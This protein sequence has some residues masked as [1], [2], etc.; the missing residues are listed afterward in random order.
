MPAMPAAVRRRVRLHRDAAVRRFDVGAIVTQTLVNVGKAIAA[1]ENKLVSLEAPFDRWVHEGKDSTRSR[2]RRSAARTLFVGK[3]SCIDCHN[4]PM[5]TDK[6]FHNIGIPQVGDHVPTAR[7]LRRGQRELRLPYDRQGRD[8]PAVGRV[9]RPVE[10][11]TGRGNKFRRVGSWGDPLSAEPD[12]DVKD[13]ALSAQYCFPVD[14]SL[15]GAWRTPSLRDVAITAPYMHDGYYRTLED[16]VWHY[17]NGGTASGTTTSVTRAGLDDRE[18]A[19]SMIPACA[20]PRSGPADAARRAAQVKPLGLTAEEMSDLV[21][22]LKTLTASR[23]HPSYVANPPD[24]SRAAAARRHGRRCRRR[25]GRGHGLM[26]RNGAWAR[27]LSFS[28]LLPAARSRPMPSLPPYPTAAGA[29]PASAA[30]A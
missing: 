19:G 27:T 30:P 5:L 17:N 3:A 21:E 23:C 24:A 9:G 20:A 29:A 2:Q 6:S 14:Q 10:V 11:E 13:H 8:L 15:K 22:F 4:G 1:Y 28:T 16:V 12:S 26:M 7:R 25:Y 18:L